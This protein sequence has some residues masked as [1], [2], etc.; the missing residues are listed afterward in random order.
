M[1][2]IELNKKDPRSEA[3]LTSKKQK[4]QTTSTKQQAPPP[5]FYEKEFLFLQ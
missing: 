3:K 2:Q 5:F 1:S 4:Q